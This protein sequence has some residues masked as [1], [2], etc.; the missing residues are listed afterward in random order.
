MNEKKL[1]HDALEQELLSGKNLKKKLDAQIRA[2]NVV[3]SAA[4]PSKQKS[5]TG[6][7][8]KWIAIPAVAMLLVLTLAIGTFVVM[9]DMQDRQQSALQPHEDGK[10]TEPTVTPEP[11]NE[12]ILTPDPTP[13]TTPVV[14]A[15][16]MELPAILGHY[17]IN[18]DGE[19]YDLLTGRF[20]IDGVKVF[21]P[22][23]NF[24]LNDNHVNLVIRENG[25]LMGWHESEP[26]TNY[27]ELMDMEYH[28]EPVHLMDHTVNAAP[29]C[30][31]ND[32]GQ[33]LLWGGKLMGGEWEQM[34]AEEQAALM[35]PKTIDGVVDVAWYC[36]LL[37][38]GTLVR[39]D[40]FSIGLTEEPEVV[41]SDVKKLYPECDY[42]TNDGTL[43]FN[44]L[45]LPNVEKVYCDSGL[46]CYYY[47]DKYD[48]LRCVFGSMD[49]TDRPALL[50]N[51]EKIFFDRYESE[52]ITYSYLYALT[53]D[54]E[55]WFADDY[56]VE[57]PYKVCD[58]AK[59][60]VSDGV[61]TYILMKDG[62][63]WAYTAAEDTL[64]SKERTD[65]PE[66][67][68]K[69]YVLVKIMESVV[70][71]GRTITITINEAGED[72]TY[73]FCS[74]FYACTDDHR[75]FERG[76]VD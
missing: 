31:I 64:Y 62:S 48:T 25:E 5:R 44:S 8:K 26:E 65:E 55:L 57:K 67:P 23:W 75:V 13:A 29:G 4:E 3:R 32:K 24:V 43:H 54:G 36:A 1:Y 47:I 63:L 11:T 22:H 30:A 49:P 40:H 58:G 38:D 74:T 56:V 6:S 10:T 68:T 41:A 27:G 18:D 20:I 59:E 19:M 2:E 17:F 69:D 39:I 61:N 66:G 45:A 71:C 35:V 60:V 28:P 53:K 42:L 16:A 70:C 21:L 72:Y 33:L 76:Y 51:V 7:M 14:S 46:Q 52:V 50:E 12:P 34:T 37:A 9:H 73:S 15:E